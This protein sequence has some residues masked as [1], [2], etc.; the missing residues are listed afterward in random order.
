[1]K[2]EKI[3]N[4]TF[5]V[6]TIVSLVIF[7]VAILIIIVPTFS[8][9]IVEIIN[10]F[11]EGKVFFDIVKILAEVFPLTLLA[12]IGVKTA[13]DLIMCSFSIT[14]N[15]KLIKSQIQDTSEEKKVNVEFIHGGADTNLLISLYQSREQ[16]KKS[17]CSGPIQD[18]LVYILASLQGCSEEL[19]CSVKSICDDM[20]LDTIQSRANA[21]VEHKV[22]GIQY[23]IS[24]A[25]IIIV[26]FD[27][28]DTEL[29]YKLGLAHALNKPTILLINTNDLPQVLITGKNVIY[30]S[31]LRD[32][33]IKLS[34]NLKEL[35]K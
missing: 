29:Y 22:Q 16:A 20:K 23:P 25:Q 27:K 10:D 6:Y 28:S 24:F 31:D 33:E 21:I 30:Y 8:V 12:L 34:E 17:T 4:K 5:I 32:L 3:T 18:H 13:K 15:L 14:P 35:L 11:V 7:V 19:F 2:K 1:M 26:I 9:Q